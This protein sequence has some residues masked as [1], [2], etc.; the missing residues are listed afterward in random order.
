MKCGDVRKAINDDQGDL[1]AVRR[2]LMACPECARRY[3][4]DLRLEDSLRGLQKGLAPVDL[5][6]EVKSALYRADRRE[7]GNAAARRWI[8]V[9]LSAALSAIIVTTAPILTGWMNSAHE[10]LS[11]ADMPGSIAP[12]VPETSSQVRAVH[13]LLA[14]A[15]VLVW[16]TLYLWRQSRTA[17]R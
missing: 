7:S 2:H 8:W 9:V 13:L 4:E 16:I 1:E 10:I 15:S 17:P 5:T 12:L 11:Q 3:S 6:A 14:M